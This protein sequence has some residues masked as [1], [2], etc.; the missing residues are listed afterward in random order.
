MMVFPRYENIFFIIAIF[1]V[2]RK[3]S[4]INY[5]LEKHTTI[6]KYMT[7]IIIIVIII[8]I[9]VIIMIMIIK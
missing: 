2:C 4:L 9:I 7:T 1:A 6:I 5:K 8:I 3:S